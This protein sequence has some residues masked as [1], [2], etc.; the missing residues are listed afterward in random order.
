MTKVNM[1]H[2]PD[3]FF[4]FFE[5]KV[6]SSALAPPFTEKLHHGDMYI[7]LNQ[8]ILR[9]KNRWF[10]A[11]IQ[12]IS[13]I[14]TIITRKQILIRFSNFDM[15][16]YCKDISQLLA[17]RDFLNLSQNYLKEKDS[18]Y[19]RANILIGNK[20]QRSIHKPKNGELQEDY[21]KISN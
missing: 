2:K 3:V 12:D 10:R 16:L 20:F 15:I 6:V 18:K 14:K 17:I 1:I 5:P 9:D 21:S 11:D 7:Y 4:N 19:P 8:L 13:I